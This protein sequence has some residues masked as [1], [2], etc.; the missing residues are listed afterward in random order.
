MS[1]VC[2]SMHMNIELRVPTQED[3]L[4]NV[5][6]GKDPDIRKLDPPAGTVSNPTVWSIYVDNTHIG[7]AII[8]NMN[9]VEQSTEFGIRIGEKEY[10]NVGVGTQVVNSIVLYCLGN[11]C[12]R[13]VYLKVLATNAHAIRC[14]EKCGFG[15]VNEFTLD[16]HR[17]VLMR[18]N[19]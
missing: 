4:R 10:W 17:F 9:T 7:M 14:Y 12:F 16:G 1:R 18:R 13:T 19:K 15:R 6:W 11:L 3:L 8:Y 5:E 2:S